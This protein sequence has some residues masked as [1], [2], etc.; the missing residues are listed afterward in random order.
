MVIASTILQFT[1]RFYIEP[2]CSLLLSPAVRELA[3]A[4]F[5][6]CTDDERRLREVESHKGGC[7]VG[8][9]QLPAKC[10]GL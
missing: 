3:S 8:K 1:K 10:L 7:E 2:S 4:C 9:W 5:P 6:F